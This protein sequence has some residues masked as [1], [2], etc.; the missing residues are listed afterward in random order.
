M[1][2][3]EDPVRAIRNPELS[4]PSP[5]SQDGHGEAPV[6]S[7]QEPNGPA[8]EAG[9]AKRGEV[10]GDRS[11]YNEA[12]RW[13]NESLRRKESAARAGKQRKFARH[14]KLARKKHYNA[15]YVTPENAIK[16][17]YVPHGAQKKFAD[18]IESGKKITLCIG[19]RQGGKTYAG[20]RECLKQIY[21]YGR[22]PNIGWIV[23]PTY[24]MSLVVER[25]FENAA[26]WFEQGGLILKKLAGQRAYL[27][28]PPKGQTEPFRVEI[29]TAE[30]PDRLRGAGLGFIWLDEAAM[31][32]EDVYQILLGCIL[33]TKGVIF[34][35]STPRGRNWFYKLF[36]DAETSPLIGAVRFKSTENVHLGKDEL[37]LMKGRLSEDFARQELDAE[38][39]SFD[40]LVYKGFNWDKHVIPPVLQIP[41]NSEMIAGIDNGYG[42]PFAHLWILK[43]DGKFYVVDEYYE[44]GRPLD[45]VANSIKTSPWDKYV[46]RRWHDPSGA[47]ERADLLDRHGIGTYPARN[48]IVAGINEVEKLFEQNRIFIAQ[49]CVNTLSEITQYHFTQRTDRNSGE[50]PVDAFNHAMDALRY[51]IFSESRYGV[52]HPVVR[53]DDYGRLQID[54]G[55]HNYMSERLEDWI[56]FPMNPVAEFP[57]PG[58]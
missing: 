37:L 30:N 5:S 27:L 54:E 26:G 32:S 49:N 25:E 16:V 47:Q 39:V 38:F 11:G 55:G 21:K 23:S 41:P 15:R 56:K 19:G 9:N 18:L 52:A 17:K 24:P 6:H 50:E 22:K 57:D 48:D 43:H 34:M 35:T 12:R 13:E 8:N 53:V 29:K 3:N 31:M 1:E 7:G 40:G 42:D 36:L 10:D 46:I 51:A 14:E 4:G 33:A 28:H 2:P 45:S 44:K 20:A 58:F